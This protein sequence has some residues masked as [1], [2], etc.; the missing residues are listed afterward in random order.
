MPTPAI[1]VQGLN[2]TLGDHHVLQNLSFK[3]TVG[4]IVSV[5]GPNGSGKTTLVKALLG[6]IPYDGT[7]S[8]FGQS[9]HEARI[10]IGY[11]PQEINF[12]RTVPMTVRELLLL[13][14][15]RKTERAAGHNS[16]TRVK[17]EH[18]ID[19]R[20]GQLSGGEFQ[21]VL[22][23]LA[24]QH[25]PELL[26]LDEPASGVDVEG[27]TIIYEMLT[28]LKEREKLT[29]L[30]VSHDL[31]VV[32]RYA[33]SVLCINHALICHGVPNEVL[34]ADRLGQLYGVGAIYHHPERP[35]QELIIHRND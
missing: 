35:H 32:Y 25:R 10:R 22:M 4:E 13:F 34:T 21:R 6:L 28:E 15:D 1:S 24:L 7:V 31:S 14:A 33:T 12:D 27:E 18:L 5:I 9:P 3:V 11:V 8:L 30:L 19:R 16:L 2:V 20:L 23:A 29:V 17:A 26:V